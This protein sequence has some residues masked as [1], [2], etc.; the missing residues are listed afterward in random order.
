M[1]EPICPQEWNDKIEIVQKRGFSVLNTNIINLTHEHKVAVHMLH[2]KVVRVSIHAI[3]TNAL[4]A[5][6]DSRSPKL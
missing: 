1:K 6:P 2:E 3:V 5:G 4:S